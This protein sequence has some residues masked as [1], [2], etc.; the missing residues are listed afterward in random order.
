MA[1]KRGLIATMRQFEKVHRREISL[2]GGIACTLM[3]FGLAIHAGYKL[4]K[5]IDDKKKKLEAIDSIPAKEFH[6]HFKS[7]EEYDKA[8]REIIFEGVKEGAMAVTPAVIACTG[9]VASQVM[10]YKEGSKIITGLSTVATMASSDLLD[11]KEM[12]KSVIGEKKEQEVQDNVNIKKM[13]ENFA[14]GGQADIINTG[15]GN[16]LFCDGVTGQFFRSDW[17]YIQK[18]VN[19]VTADWQT[20]DYDDDDEGSMLYYHLL[21]EIGLPSNCKAAMAFAFKPDR[22]GRKEL[23]LQNTVSSVTYGD[24]HESAT[25]I[26]FRNKPEITTRYVI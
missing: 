17:N 10:G 16:V 12:A 13:K 11:Y 9:S 1:K 6:E 26:D 25:I 19:T 8:R 5:I 3:T 4:Y 14:S 20:G 7:E 23:L 2:G 22:Y 24:T 21:D 18:C 15:T